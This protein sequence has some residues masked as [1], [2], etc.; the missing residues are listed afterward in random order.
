MPT[1]ITREWVADDCRRRFREQ[2]G[3]N[4]GVKPFGDTAEIYQSIVRLGDNPAI[5]DVEAILPGWTKVTCDE[6]NKPVDAV[7]Q[8][9]EMPD[10]ESST[11]L[12]CKN[13]LAAAFALFPAP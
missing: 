8:V 1:L 6:C 4:F 12:I 2:Y 11:A 5:A 7:V 13:C 9:G 3:P 10:Y